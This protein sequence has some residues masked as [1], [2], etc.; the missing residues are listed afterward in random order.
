MQKEDCPNL[1]LVSAAFSWVCCGAWLTISRGCGVEGSSR[2]SSVPSTEMGVRLVVP[3]I[4]P[5]LH[6][7]SGKES[8]LETSLQVEEAQGTWKL[9]MFCSL[10]PRPRPRTPLCTSRAVGARSFF[11]GELSCAVSWSSPFRIQQYPTCCDNPDY[12]Q[13]VPT[14][15]GGKPA[16]DEDT[17]SASETRP[18]SRTLTCWLQSQMP[19]PGPKDSGATRLLHSC[20]SGSSLLDQ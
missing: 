1:S 6:P 14:V 5:P 18:H 8:G 15:P 16:P 3:H 20:P 10:D 2:S 4:H 9:R 12:P 17:S 19:S 13:T 11:A 7:A